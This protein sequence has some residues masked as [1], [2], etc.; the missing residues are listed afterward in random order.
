MSTMGKPW[1]LITFMQSKHLWLDIV[2][3]H[4]SHWDADGYV[5]IKACLVAALNR[6]TG[7]ASTTHNP[8]GHP[9][10][11]VLVGVLRLF[12]TSHTSMFIIRSALGRKMERT[13]D[14]AGGGFTMWCQVLCHRGR[15]S[16]RGFHQSVQNIRAP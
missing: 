14:I 7:F 2:G 16:T 8:S 13:G 15:P 12:H 11:S 9:S 5:G 4:D 1:L 6:A 10:S 3:L